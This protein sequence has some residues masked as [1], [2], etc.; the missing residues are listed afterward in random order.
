MSKLKIF[1]AGH[2]GMVGSALMRVLK[3]NDIELIIK[4]RKE[5]NLLNQ[6]EV[7]NFLMNKIL[8]KYT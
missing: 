2:G 4:N 6:N 5:L 8:I 3:S 1:V 7:Y